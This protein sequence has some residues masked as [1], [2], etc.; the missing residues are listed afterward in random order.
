M[1][2]VIIEDEK[3]PA[4]ALE[5]IIREIVPGVEIL[6]ILQTIE[7]SVEWFSAHPTPDL[8]FMDIHLA[9]GS[10]FLIFEQVQIKC[11]IIF[12]TAYDEY[13]LKAFEVNSVD[14]LLKPINKAHVERALEK[15]KTITST[16]FNLSEHAD[17]I[18]KLASSVM[19][20]PS[21]KSSI[22]I[23]V[24]DLLVPLPVKDIAYIYIDNKMVK[25]V[26]FDEK[27][28]ALD[29]TLDELEKQLDP[30]DFY[31]ANR[32]YIVARAA[33]KNI[34]IWFGNRMAI[35]LTVPT[36]ERILV[37]RTN[38]RELKQWITE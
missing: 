17:I 4:Q 5:K 6:A 38:V 9:D 22:L 33:V 32:Q 25:A 7:E 3:L 37:S 31:R 24:K 10:S 26:R 11:P 13:A 35:N 16:G 12:T 29:S 20:K 27:S 2:I 23:S 36:P 18:N 28:L 8:A 1:K 21:Y 14:Y 15:L 34:A 30:H 19:Q